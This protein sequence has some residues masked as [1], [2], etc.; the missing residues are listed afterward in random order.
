MK[1]KFVR[2]TET[3][4]TAICMVKTNRFAF[5]SGS[6]LYLDGSA[7]REVLG[8]NAAKGDSFDLPKVSEVIDMVWLDE[9]GETVTATTKQGIVLKTIE[10]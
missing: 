1:A 3:G 8:E 2:F 9:H 10:G 4:K 6:P 7:V 5:G